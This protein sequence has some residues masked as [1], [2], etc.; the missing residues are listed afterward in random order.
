MVPSR[1]VIIKL[2]GLL[3]VP[4]S[5]VTGAVPHCN[6]IFPVDRCVAPRISHNLIILSAAAVSSWVDSVVWNLD[7][8]T[9]AVWDITSTSRA[10]G[11]PVA[12]S[13]DVFVA[14]STLKTR[15]VLSE[16][17][18]AKYAPLEFHDTL[19]EL[20]R[21][22]P[23]SMTVDEIKSKF[24]VVVLLPISFHNIVIVDCQ[25]SGGRGFV[26]SVLRVAKQTNKQNKTT[27]PLI[28]TADN[29]QTTCRDVCS[30]DAYDE[31]EW[32]LIFLR[33]PS[34]RSNKRLIIRNNRCV[35]NLEDLLNYFK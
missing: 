2:W 29:K 14:V 12:A 10:D 4:H 31:I 24:V 15:A 3:A 20:T 9:T 32:F 26:D 19:L 6:S 30:L 22:G 21:C 1:S 23:Q 5:V 27:T 34:A 16:D 18:L 13:F 7:F 35:R 28:F 17:A 8:T 33:D 25:S 11:T